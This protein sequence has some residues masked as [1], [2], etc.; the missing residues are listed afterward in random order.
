MIQ[1][2][3]PM[4][5]R[6]RSPR[7]SFMSVMGVTGRFRWKSSQVRPSSSDTY[8]PYSVPA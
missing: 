3:R 2:P 6:A 4:V 5:E 1:K 8:N 7:T